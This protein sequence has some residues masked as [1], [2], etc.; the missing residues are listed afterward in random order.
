MTLALSI[1]RLRTPFLQRAY[2]EWSTR[3]SQARAD[4]VFADSQATAK[5]LERFYRTPRSKIRVVYPGVD[6]ANQRPTAEA[7]KAVR[8]KYNLPARYFLTIGTLQPRKNIKGIAQAFAQWRQIQ[9][10]NECRAGF[11]WRQG[12]AI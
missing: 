7:V 8:A 3:F 9:R 12:L 11:G 5:D 4:I 10:E 2:L 1:S 6:S